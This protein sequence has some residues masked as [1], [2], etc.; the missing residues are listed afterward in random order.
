[1]VLP[2]LLFEISL[3]WRS[4]FEKITIAQLLGAESRAGSANTRAYDRA[5]RLWH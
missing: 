5:T 4:L 1:M 3:V 2:G